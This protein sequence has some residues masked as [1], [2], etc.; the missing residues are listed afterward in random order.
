MCVCVCVL[1]M[2]KIK[3]LVNLENVSLGFSFLSK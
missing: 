1:I 2:D 3:E